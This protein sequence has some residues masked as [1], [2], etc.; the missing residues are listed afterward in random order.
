MVRDVCYSF[1]RGWLLI[2]V[3]KRGLG[4]T[5]YALDRNG[6]HRVV[7]LGLSK[8]FYFDVKINIP[9]PISKLPAIELNQANLGGVYGAWTGPDFR[10]QARLLRTDS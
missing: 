10:L 5:K 7:G 9:P 6:V 3:V 8:A 1:L 2:D 4:S